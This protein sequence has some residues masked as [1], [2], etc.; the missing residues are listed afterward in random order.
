MT[1]RQNCGRG[2]SLGTTTYL[3]IVLGGRRGHAPCRTLYLHESLF[4]VGRI[5]WRSF[6]C[7]RVVVNM[8]TLSL[9][10]INGFKPVLASCFHFVDAVCFAAPLVLYGCPPS[11]CT[12]VP[13]VLYGC[14]PHAERLS[15][16][17]CTAV[18]IVLYGCPPS[19]CTAVAFCRTGWRSR[20]LCSRPLSRIRGSRTPR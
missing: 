5:S 10:D 12:A 3:K 9:G 20:R 7:H 1:L 16:S 14:P 2:E 15:P 18:S 11:F 13:L 6:D 17:C 8:G 4:C 19:C